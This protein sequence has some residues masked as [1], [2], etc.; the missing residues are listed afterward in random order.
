MRI[1]YDLEKKDYVAGLEAVCDTIMRKPDHARFNRRLKVL[2][3]GR[4]VIL[5]VATF[6]LAVAFKAALVPLLL[7]ASAVLLT[8]ALISWLLERNTAAGIG[9]SYDR[10]RHRGLTLDLNA[11]GIVLQ[12]EGYRHHWAWSSLMHL[13]DLRRVYAL[14]FIGHDMIVVP[15]HAFA[16]RAEEARWAAT[17][18]RHLAD[19]EG[20]APVTSPA[21]TAQSRAVLSQYYMHMD[22]IRE[23][24]TIRAH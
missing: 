1:A 22:I 9:A 15:K 16:A 21:L 11:G 2:G 19:P 18:R 17:V 10:R 8:D 5:G 6:G 24:H 3:T 23:S 7:L 20:G 13:H 12:G 4:I 14:E